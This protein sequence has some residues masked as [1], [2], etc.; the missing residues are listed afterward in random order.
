MIPIAGSRSK[1]TFLVSFLIVSSM[2]SYSASAQTLEQ[3]TGNTTEQVKGQEDTPAKGDVV[4]ATDLALD[5]SGI[6]NDLKLLDSENSVYTA[7]KRLEAIGTAPIPVTVIPRYYLAALDGENM[8]QILR[9]FPGIDVVQLT[10]TDYSVDIRGYFTRS[11]F[12]PKDVLVLVDNRTVYDDY[13][14]NV[15]WD[16]L[17]ILPEDVGKI[18]IIRGGASA[19]Y[20]ANAS[21]GVINIITKP[22][23]G[24]P[25]LESDTSFT[26]R[27]IRERVATSQP[28]GPVAL[29]LS[30]SYDHADIW[31][32]FEE[33]VRIPDPNGIRV[34]R[35]N[36]GLSK[37]VGE[38]GIL[39]L[40][41]GGN[42]GE[43]LQHTS[44][45]T[46]L[47]ND[48]QT[49]HVMIEYEHPS[50]SVRSFWNYH[51]LESFGALSGKFGSRRTQNLYDLEVV[52]RVAQF[53]RSHLSWG[54]D[55]RFTEVK[56]DRID[57]DQGQ[58]TTGIFFDE[59]YNFTNDLLFRLAGRFDYQEESGSQFSPRVGITY[60]INPE[61]IVKASVS[62][63]YR[64]PTLSDNF[65]LLK[66]GG[67]TVLGNPDLK[68]ERSIWYETGY[69]AQPIPD[70]RMGIDLF[71]VVTNNLIQ[72]VESPVDPDIFNTVNVNEHVLGRGGE[73]WA[74]YRVVRN[75]RLLANY[76]YAGYTK[77]SD[78][79]TTA[80]HKVNFGIL[81]N[82]VRN[83]T[84][85]LTFH[86]VGHASGYF[87]DQTVSSPSY[88]TVNLFLGYEITS[89]LS[90]GVH[91]TNLTNR[92]H[93]EAPIIGEEI[94]S[95]YYAT[96]VLR[97]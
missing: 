58:W 96:I 15:E 57:G 80:P 17:S 73:I 65:L 33:G 38:N 94:G 66:L 21:R 62:E 92:R 22:P 41:A 55:L 84:G 5:P 18:E 69:L 77:T 12:R 8:P 6:Y 78:I 68:P 59:Q 49:D 95:D 86:Y 76:A 79:A 53:G 87:D 91:L 7:S 20:G 44:G 31:N 11:N 3:K 26:S 72:I 28:I 29:T 85:A 64:S 47:R 25:Y 54:G 75:V 27:G 13:S 9:L 50:L 70:L 63:G 88:Y 89:N 43:V 10:R 93:R 14:G 60:Q 56:S 2:E 24:L 46:L 39:K 16:T 97:I 19:I 37:N 82:A 36:L 30:G 32:R 35:Y 52:G 23:E 34:W 4:A 40:D 51:D 48:Q 45:G 1:V 74:D 81:F 71:Y 90:A 83:L 42:T 61:N 67:A